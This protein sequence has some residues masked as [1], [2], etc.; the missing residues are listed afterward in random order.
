[1]QRHKSCLRARLHAHSL[2][3]LHVTPRRARAGDSLGALAAAIREFQGGVLLISHNSEFT[4]ALCPE[5]WRVE[6]GTVTV[7]RQELRD[8][9]KCAAV[10]AAAAVTEAAEAK[11]KGAASA[12]GEA[13]GGAGENGAAE[14]A[15]A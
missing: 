7:E 8:E 15:A 2:A 12:G 11:G 3:K 5:V 6:N 14:A 9:G 10:A 4:S 13:A 1:V